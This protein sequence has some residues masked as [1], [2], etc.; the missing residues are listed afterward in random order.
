M[1]VISGAAARLPPGL[2]QRLAHYRYQVFVEHLGWQLPAQGEAETD[3]FDGPE[4]VYVVAEEPNGELSGCARLLPTSSPY[5][6]SRNFPEVLNGAP[7]PCDST[8]WELS[9]FC[10]VQLSSRKHTSLSDFPNSSAA[11]L[12]RAAM[13]C[14]ADY[15]AR[16]LVTVTA[17]AMERLI[18]RLGIHSHR[19]GPPCVV[20]GEPIYGCWIEL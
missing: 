15:G 11:M 19:M 8:I 20:N 3:P 12:M 18:R 16:R 17:L 7:A 9:R 1:R 4:A 14:A 13:S 10:A 6:L 5:L 2:Y